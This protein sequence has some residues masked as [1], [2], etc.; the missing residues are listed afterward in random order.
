MIAVEDPAAVRLYFVLTCSSVMSARAS[1]RGINHLQ[2]GGG[3]RREVLPRRRK[4]GGLATLRQEHVGCRHGG[5]SGRQA[6][7]SY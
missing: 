3:M 5:A 1:Q 2:G 6:L 7:G 4:G